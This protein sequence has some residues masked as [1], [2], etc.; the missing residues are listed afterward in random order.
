MTK[1]ELQLQVKEIGDDRDYWRREYAKLED[2]AKLN[3]RSKYLKLEEDKYAL[4]SQVRNLMEIIRWQINPSTARSPF[5][6][7]KDERDN[8]K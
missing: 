4:Q 2:I 1:K 6:P 7:T 3:E 8:I 5:T